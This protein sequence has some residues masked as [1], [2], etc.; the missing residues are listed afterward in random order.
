MTEPEIERLYRSRRHA[1]QLA[2]PSPDLLDL[3]EYLPGMDP[4]QARNT[5]GQHVA[6]IRIG[7]CPAGEGVRHS[8][9]AW[10]EDP[11]CAAVDRASNWVGQHSTV[12]PSA[13][14][15]G[16][17]AAG[18]RAQGVDGW[19]AGEVKHDLPSL[20]QE[21][22]AAATVRYPAHL[23]AQVTVP[24]S[25]EGDGDG[26]VD[27]QCAY[28]WRVVLESVSGLMLAGQ[29]AAALEPPGIVRVVLQLAGFKDAAPFQFTKARTG[30]SVEGMVRAPDGLVEEAVVPALSLVQ[31]PIDVARGLLDR[32]LA[33]FYRGRDLYGN[34]FGS[35]T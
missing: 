3:A 30:I 12:G 28:E 24:L 18:W 16:L 15:E 11:L 31:T 21:L 17:A 7:C 29:W 6:M 4:K 34:V 14:L 20:L 19:A 25:R 8:A 35:L 2:G 27:Y 5:P 23:L 33:A 22:T 1:P 10:L 32:W 9:G 26:F 13:L